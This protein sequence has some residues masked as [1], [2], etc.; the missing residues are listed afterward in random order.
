MAVK[1][2][3]LVA[4]RGYASRYPENTLP[5]LK[6][7]VEA[8]ATFL[9]FDVQLCRDQVPVLMHDIDVARTSGQ[10][11]CIWDLD[12]VNLAQL[13]VGEPD[14]F[15]ASFS[16]VCV[17]VLSDVVEW[18]RS[19]A[20]VTAFVELKIESLQRFGIK[21][22]LNAVMDALEPVRSRAILISYDIGLL[23]AVR[24]SDGMPVG[25]VV[26]EWNQ[27]SRALATGCAPDYL[28]CNWKRFPPEGRGL[29]EGAW[30]WMSYEVTDPGQAIALA[31]RGVDFVETMAIGEMLKDPLFS[32]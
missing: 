20:G 26:P 29:W 22:M 9:E 16:D 7:A 19:H 24:E 13:P 10:S 2:P 25:W 31:A 3:A 1:R 18:W 11:A 23:Q 6:A 27:R 30:K 5:A 4:H 17:P 28:I 32:E 12:S 14:R 8:G 21:P 15:G